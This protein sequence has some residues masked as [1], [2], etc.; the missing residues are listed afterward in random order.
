VESVGY[1]IIVILIVLGGVLVLLAAA[2]IDDDDEI[3]QT[4]SSAIGIPGIVEAGSR[5]ASRSRHT[6]PVVMLVPRRWGEIEQI[7]SSTEIPGSSVRV[8]GVVDGTLSEL[9]ATIESA[10]A[11]LRDAVVTFVAG[12]D[13][14]LAGQPLDSALDQLEGLLERLS[15]LPAMAVIGS[16]PDLAHALADDGIDVSVESLSA[17]VS[18]WNDAVADVAR[19]YSA[20]FVDLSSVPVAMLDSGVNANK[21]A[22]P[23]TAV[24]MKAMTPAISRAADRVR[25]FRANS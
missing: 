1:W 4:P 10:H 14:F 3:E 8:V 7:A 19:S 6:V 21:I 18:V 15:D 24:L 5:G 20:E 25:S 13:D 11:D 12:P 2:S 9:T 22:R 23:D 16:I 17:A